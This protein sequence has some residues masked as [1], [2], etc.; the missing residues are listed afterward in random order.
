MAI[1]N[2]SSAQTKKSKRSGSNTGNFYIDS[3]EVSSRFRIFKDFIEEDI[4]KVLKSSM[5]AGVKLLAEKAKEILRRKL[6]NAFVKG[7]KYSDT[8]AEGVRYG[9]H[10]YE[11]VGVT[12]ILGKR[13][14]GSGTFRLRFFEKG[15]KHV[16]KN[17]KTWQNSPA[18]HFFKEAKEN[19]T[20]V[21]NAIT[22]KFTQEM[23]K[24]T[25]TYDL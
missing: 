5:R 21:E 17:D 24:M 10:K 23:D 13:S 12:H 11:N 8:M 19:S 18:L 1:Q 15:S 14:K 6:P 16:G 22:Q 7:N 4:D 25:Q 2:R 20:Q 3:G 9:V